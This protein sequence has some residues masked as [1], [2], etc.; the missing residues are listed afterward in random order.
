MKLTSPIARTLTLVAL[1]VA[2][3]L[4]F[5]ASAHFVRGPN[6]S[7][8]GTNGN[9]TVTWK[10][11]GLGDTTQIDYMA[12][13]NGS[14]RY[15]CVN[16]GGKCPAASNK[17]DALGPVSASG[18]FFSGKNGAINGSL[19]FEPPAGT[20][21]CPGGQVLKMVSASFTDIALSDLTNGVRAGA[22]PSALAM[23][24]PECP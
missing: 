2:A 15:Q 4:T 18:A 5:A 11:A 9:V 7:L 10:E 8:N 17:Q 19:T 12:T 1:G 13:A 21:R 3:G 6:A 14:A 20:L 22:I 16:R 23:S 24:G